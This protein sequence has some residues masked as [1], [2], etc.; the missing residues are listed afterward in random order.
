VSEE[1]RGHSNII[2]EGPDVR[3]LLPSDGRGRARL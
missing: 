1:E 2:E 3:P